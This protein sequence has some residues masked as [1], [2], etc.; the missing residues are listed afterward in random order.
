MMKMDLDLNKFTDTIFEKLKKEFPIKDFPFN[1]SFNIN[2]YNNKQYYSRQ[3]V[4]INTTGLDIEFIYKYYSII[5]DEIRQKIARSILKD[6]KLNSS[7]N[8]V[9]VMGLDDVFLSKKLY[10]DFEGMNIKN[11]VC[12]G[13]LYS[14]FSDLLEY[15][16]E[17]K[18]PINNIVSNS[19]VS[20]R[21]KLNNISL[22]VDSVMKWTDDYI[23]VYDEIYY[24]VHD[25][26]CD[27]VRGG[28]HSF[29]E[30]IEISFYLY[31]KIVNPQ[32][33]YLIEDTDSS[34][35][36]GFKSILRNN[37]IDKLLG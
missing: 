35:Y 12:N 21:G 4:H 24:D 16:Y 19:L 11:I 33:F 5:S 28:P 10:L 23:L 1:D 14:L 37:K 9:N 31:L 25:L 22:H 34:G 15:K 7:E 30:V 17:D 18:F 13:R 20:K 26:K 36:L 8:F 6:M 2:S 3:D 29:G 27:L 32:I